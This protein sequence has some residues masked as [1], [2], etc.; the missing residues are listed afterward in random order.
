[1]STEAAAHRPLPNFKIIY[2]IGCFY[3]AGITLTSAVSVVKQLNLTKFVTRGG[4]NRAAT[5]AVFT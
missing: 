4:R 3:F 2:K 5:A 1:M